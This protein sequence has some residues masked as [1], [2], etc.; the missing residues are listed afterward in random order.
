MLFT[1]SQGKKKKKKH[2]HQFPN[3]SYL[4]YKEF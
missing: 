1:N 2:E 3:L 4:L